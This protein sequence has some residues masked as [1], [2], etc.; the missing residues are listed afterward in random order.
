MRSKFNYLIWP[1]LF[2]IAGSSQLLAQKKFE[3]DDLAKLTN[4]SDPQIS[5]DGKS[6]VIVVSRPD[7]QKN[8]Y[9][10]EL[11]LV[12]I[13]SGKQRVLTFDRFSVSQPRWSPSGDQL[14]FISRAGQGR[15]SANQIFVLNMGGGEARQLTKASSGIQHY[16]WS[17]DGSSIAFVTADE[18]TTKT[19]I[20]RG[21]DAFEVGNNDMFLS[22]APPPAHIW[23]IGAQGGEAKR[24]TSGTWSLPVT[25]PPGA[26]SSP[27]SWSPDSKSIAFVKV[28]TPYSGDSGNRSIQLLTVADQSIK[29]LSTRTKLESY[30]TFSPDGSRVCYWL[31]KDFIPGNINEIWVSPT[32]GGEGKNMTAGLDRDIYRA[33]WMPDGKSFIMGGHDDNKTSLWIQ[34]IDGAA[35]KI[36]LGAISPSWSFWIDMN[37][38]KNGSVVFTGSDP[39]SPPELYFLMNATSAPRKLTDF[40]GEVKSMT[41]GKTE[42]IRWGLEGLSH[43]GIV[44]YPSEYK[45]GQKYPLVLIVHGG[46]NA[47]SVEQF[48]RLSQLFSN[49]GYFVFEPNYRGSDNQG[50]KYKTAIIRDAGAGPGRDVMAGL[51]QLK[52]SGMID[53]TRIGVTGWSYGGYMTVWLAGHYAGWKATMAGAAVTDWLDQYNL[54]DGNVNVANAIGG[55]PYKGNM[56]AYIDQSPITNAHKITAPTLILANT[57]DPRVPISQSYKLYHALKDNGVTTKFIAW[58]IP[59]HNASDPVRQKEMYKYWIGWMDNYLQPGSANMNTSLDGNKD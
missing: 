21:N 4:I 56:Q 13:A 36:N 22:N 38:G 44:T 45:A 1:L 32:S 17:P 31:K 24:M 19:E 25:I 53:T 18:L 7:Y 50:S 30:P 14:T 43:S 12:D 46:P 37:V 49:R 5:P 59:A 51:R 34:L 42:T 20:E 39:S 47:A 40:N 55:S 52:N 29:P 11:V 27:L 54:G 3:V 33:I 26:P 15:E 9:N 23:L 6:V 16:A 28:T 8:R 48:S 35:K 41:M 2:V 58:P 10:G 57:E